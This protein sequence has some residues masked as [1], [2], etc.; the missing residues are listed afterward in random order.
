LGPRDEEVDVKL[1]SLHRHR[2]RGVTALALAVP[3]LLVTASCGAGKSGSPMKAAHKEST[4]PADAFIRLDPEQFAAWIGYPTAFVINVHVPYEGE[5][6]HTDVFI[7]FDRILQDS[8][9]PADK[10]T[11]IFLYCKTG[12]MSAIAGEA[13]SRAGYRHVSHLEGGMKAWEAAGKPVIHKPQEGEPS[14][15]PHS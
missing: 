2:V 11:E 1:P 5:L 3:V 13:L 12:H 10:D 15:G 9:L 4:Q 7:P 6:E 8:R 14:G